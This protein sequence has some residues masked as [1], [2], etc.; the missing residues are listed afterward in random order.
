MM[1]VYLLIWAAVMVGMRAGIEYLDPLADDQKAWIVCTIV[2]VAACVAM[3]GILAHYR[4]KS[5]TASP[6][7]GKANVPGGL[8]G[9]TV[10]ASSAVSMGSMGGYFAD[11]SC[12]PDGGGGGDC[13][14][15][16]K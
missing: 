14:G 15:G 2:A 9:S 6:Y 1:F 4:K 13:G 8:T 11:S 7:V 12:G 10:L 5:S 16:G 3:A